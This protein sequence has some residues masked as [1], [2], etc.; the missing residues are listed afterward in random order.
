MNRADP[1]QG[2]RP[3]HGLLTEMQRHALH[4]LRVADDGLAEPVLRAL[5]Q[6][7]VVGY[8]YTEATLDLSGETAIELQRQGLVQR[9]PSN[10]ALDPTDD[11]RFSL[12]LDPA[13][14][15]AISPAST[16][17]TPAQSTENATADTPT[18]DRASATEIRST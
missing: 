1:L 15:T 8:E 6:I 4:Q 14:S 10:G 11:V 13:A 12:L 18:C 5:Y 2:L 7:V 3:R 16:D 17:K 9:G